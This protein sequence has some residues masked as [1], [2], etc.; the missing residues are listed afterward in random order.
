MT[1]PRPEALVLDAVMRLLRAGGDHA[2]AGVVAESTLERL[3][4][5]ETWTLDQR[6]VDAERFALVLKPEQFVWVKERSGAADELRKAVA[7]VIDTPT[8][9]LAGLTLVVA[10]G[11]PETGSSAAAQTWGSVYRTSAPSHE[12]AA[13]P[14]LVLATAA[15]LARAY[16]DA[17]VASMLD[18]AELS[19]AEMS[20]REGITLVR[21]VVRLAAPDLVHAERSTSIGDLLVRCVTHAA[22]RA[23]ER[24][25][26][27]ELRARDER[28]GPR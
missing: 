15:S 6:P 12:P 11:A 23:G 20:E 4:G 22:T 3:P 19:R 10:L 28:V 21:W 26:E 2:L 7:S 1:D 24:V 27:V 16:G 18:A 25:G 17:T 14:E 9:R 8:T 5:S 13:E